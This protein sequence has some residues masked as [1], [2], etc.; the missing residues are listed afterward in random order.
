[1]PPTCSLRST[2]RTTKTPKHRTIHPV[3]TVKWAAVI[4]AAKATTQLFLLAA[5]CLP[6]FANIPH[7]PLVAEKPHLGLQTLRT[8]S[9]PGPTLAISNTATG[10]GVCLYDSGIRP[11]C[12]GKERDAETGLD[13]LE[14]RYFSSAQGRFTSPDEPL[15]D[16]W[17]H[18]PQSWNLYS[19]VRN[20]PL[21]SIDPTG[22]DCVTLDGGA[23]GDDGKGTVCAAAELD[24]THG[25][26]VQ[27]NGVSVVTVNHPPPTGPSRDGIQTEPDALLN[28]LPVAKIALGLGKIA[29]VAGPAIAMAMFR[30]AGKFVTGQVIKRV[31]QTS[32]GPLVMEA[33]VEVIGD[34][35]K[36]GRLSFAH[37]DGLQV[38]TEPGVGALKAGIDSLRGELVTAG[39]SKVEVTALRMTG[40]N[41]PRLIQ[42]TFPLK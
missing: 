36:L 30:G 7:T 42:K 13:F 3:H 22:H 1:M 14:A 2:T 23:K 41:S 12:S 9:R 40:A 33:T 38:I 10:F 37:P 39:F 17:A 16:Q 19:Y 5:V 31:I 29:T 21:R 26:V 27:S 28:A 6:A 4:Q 18:D 11:C 35:I 32:E 25:V 34:T 8:T 15:I 24:T 20:N